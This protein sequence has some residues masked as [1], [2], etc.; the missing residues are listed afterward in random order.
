MKNCRGDTSSKWQELFPKTLA[1]I[2]SF[3]PVSLIQNGNL[4]V[5]LAILCFP[6]IHMISEIPLILKIMILP[7]PDLQII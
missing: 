1:N 2:C 5:T 7:R 4:F 3:W 6:P